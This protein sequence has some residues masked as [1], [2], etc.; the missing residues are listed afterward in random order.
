LVDKEKELKAVY[1]DQYVI[2]EFIP[3]S[4]GSIHVAL[5]LYGNDG[6]I[7]G[8]ALSHSTLT[9]MTWGGGGNAGKLVYNQEVLER[10]KTIV[11]ALGGWKGPINLEFK[12]H[13]KTGQF[14]LMEINC[15][16]N[17]YSYLTTMNGMNYPA[18]IID[19]LTK[20]TTEFL[21]MPPPNKAQNFIVTLREKP[22]QNWVSGE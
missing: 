22:V 9:F 21:S 19:L 3:G 15:R 13:A 16:L 20:G 14:Y 8:E 12:Q 10:A 11:G 2:Q 5:L 18:S 6:K 7:Y 1:G 4:T 17:G